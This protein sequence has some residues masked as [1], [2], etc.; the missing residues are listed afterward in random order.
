M[1][2]IS[3][4]LISLSFSQCRAFE[5]LVSRQCGVMQE[6][7]IKVDILIKGE[8]DIY[9]IFKAGHLVKTSHMHESANPSTKEER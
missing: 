3:V 9:Q 7:F 6:M 4:H 8:G 1:G 2:R 5:R